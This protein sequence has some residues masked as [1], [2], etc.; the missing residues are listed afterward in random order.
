MGYLL[1]LSID[2]DI[3][4]YTSLFNCMEGYLFYILERNL[5]CLSSAIAS[6]RFNTAFRVPFS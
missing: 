5:T 6:K 3:G 4:A 2:N 1:R